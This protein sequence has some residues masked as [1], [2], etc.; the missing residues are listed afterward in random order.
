MVGLDAAGKTTILYACKS[1]SE[2]I[3]STIPTIGFNLEMVNIMSTSCRVWDVGGQEK[4]KMLYRHQEP[5]PVNA[6]IWVQDCSD[7]DRT[8][9]AKDELFKVL[10]SDDGGSGCPLLLFANK[11]DLPQA[12]DADELIEHFDLHSLDGKRPWQVF[13]TIATQNVG[14]MEG[15]EWLEKVVADPGYYIPQN[16]IAVNKTKSANKV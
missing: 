8:L 6:I 9:E 1:P 5:V 14:L 16:T 3:V 11:Q 2:E 15:F 12:F 10:N 13:N 7:H 4:I